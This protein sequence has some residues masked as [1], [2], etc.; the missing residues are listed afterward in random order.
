VRVTARGPWR[1]LLLIPLTLAWISVAA[2]A[3]VALTAVRSLASLALV[4]LVLLAVG[5]P[6]TAVL[7][8]AWVAGT[9][10]CDGGV[11][12]STVLR[13]TAIPWDAV[14][15]VR[16]DTDRVPWCGTPP[17]IAGERVVLDTAEGPIPTTI[18]SSS[19]DL[20]LRP[21]AWSAARDRVRLW[22]RESRADA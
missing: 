8:R 1:L 7:V 14:T 12:V 3:L 9:F 15:G 18:T 21:Q 20:W 5:L 2:P 13:T 17:P 11:K 22:W 19:P 10:V 4:V 6:V 16:V